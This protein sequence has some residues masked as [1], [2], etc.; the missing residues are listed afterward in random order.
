MER[1]WAWIADMTGDGIVT[2]GDIWAWVGWLF[3]YPGDI[4]I[5][6]ML[7]V[8]GF[9]KFFELTPAHYGGALSFL[10]S[11]GFWML[12]CV[13]LFFSWIAIE[14]IGTLGKTK[15]KGGQSE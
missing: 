1:Q 11:L 10:I 9:A 12:L 6:G 14:V 3:Y 8:E 4:A 2:I 7:K 5:Y 15:E 13:L